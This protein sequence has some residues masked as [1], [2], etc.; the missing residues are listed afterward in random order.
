MFGPGAG[1]A[2]PGGAGGAGG[3]DPAMMQQLFGLGAAGGGGG[4][5][6]FGA[7]NPFGG[8]GL[9]GAA[10]AAPA[11]TRAPEERFQV[12]LQVSWTLAWMLHVRLIRHSAAIERHGLHKRVT[13]RPRFARDCWERAFRHRV[14]SRRGWVVDVVRAKLRNV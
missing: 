1:G 4:S 7:G 13:E 9:G 14:H 2:S 12:Q 8:G 10:P 3:F 6:A 11:D 5:N